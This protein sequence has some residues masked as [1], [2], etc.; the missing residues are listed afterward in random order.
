MYKLYGYPVGELEGD[1]TLGICASA[2]TILGNDANSRGQFHPPSLITGSENLITQALGSAAFTKCSDRKPPVIAIFNLHTGIGTL[3]TFQNLQH[4]S[5]G[6]NNRL[7]GEM[8]RV[9]C[10]QICIVFRHCHL[11]EH[12]ILRVREIFLTFNTIR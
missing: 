6:H 11:I 12:N 3:C 8:L 5:R 10:Y 4:L 9:A 7:L 1:V 2:G